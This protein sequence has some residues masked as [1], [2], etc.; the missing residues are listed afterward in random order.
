MYAVHNIPGKPLGTVLSR[1]G[2]FACGSV[3][4]RIEIH[5]K[6]AHAAHPEDAINPIL[7][8]QEFIKDVT[9]LATRA[10]G[11]ALVTPIALRA[12]EKTFGTTPLKSIVLLTMRAELSEDLEFMME[13]TRNCARK[14]SD[15]K[16]VHGDLRFEEYFPVTRNEKFHSEVIAACNHLSVPFEEMEVPFR[17]SEDFG[18]FRER[19]DTHMF[20]LGSGEDTAPLHASTYD[21]PDEL[22]DRGAEVFARLFYQHHSK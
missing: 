5:G 16:G 15:M 19:C 2:T 4:V 17:W 14:M 20:G 8:S 13:E 10:K 21:F 3:G 6:T 12:G 18:H 9:A 1:S 22:I 7:L 11:F